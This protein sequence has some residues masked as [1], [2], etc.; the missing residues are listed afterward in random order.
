MG[1]EEVPLEWNEFELAAACLAMWSQRDDSELRLN[2]R[3]GT[4][5]T[6]QSIES[7]QGH[8][9]VSGR[10]RRHGVVMASWQVTHRSVMG[11]GATSTR[12]ENHKISVVATTLSF[13]KV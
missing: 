10:Q 12:L 6:V 8:T 2:E 3:E 7:E 4:A 9:S 1:C 11:R 13:R 5:R